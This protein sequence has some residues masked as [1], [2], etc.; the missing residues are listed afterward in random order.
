MAILNLAFGF[1][2]LLAIPSVKLFNL[3]NWLIPP[4]FCGVLAALYVLFHSKWM[5]KYIN[6]IKPVYYVFGAANIS[7]LLGFG[8]FIRGAQE[9]AN[10]L[11]AAMFVGAYFIIPALALYLIG[12]IALAV[13]VARNIMLAKKPS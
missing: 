2:I 9:G 3:P 5:R 11:A 7:L 6:T 12:S 1:S 8:V 4:G 13:R 10:T